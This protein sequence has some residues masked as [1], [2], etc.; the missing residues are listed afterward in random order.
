M[1]LRRQSITGCQLGKSRWVAERNLFFTRSDDFFAACANFN[2]HWRPDAVSLHDDAANKGIVR[3]AA[4]VAQQIVDGVV[5]G[6][7][8]HRMVGAIAV[9]GLQLVEVRDE[10][11][12]ATAERFNQRE[13]PVLSSGQPYHH[14]GFVS[15]RK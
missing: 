8:D 4:S 10:F 13:S 12:F 5:A 2:R 15:T 3:R 14:G 11:Q 6:V 9:I 1:A 7:P